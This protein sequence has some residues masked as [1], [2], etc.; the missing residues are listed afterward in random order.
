MSP[1]IPKPQT[2]NL[3]L[4]VVTCE[5]SNKRTASNMSTYLPGLGRK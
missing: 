1:M 5:W 2:K 4:P 3:P